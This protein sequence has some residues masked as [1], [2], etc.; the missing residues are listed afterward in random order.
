MIPTQVGSIV[1]A[2]LARK[3]LPRLGVAVSGSAMIFVLGVSMLAAAFI[4]RETSPLLLPVIIVTCYAVASVAAFVALTT[5][6]MGLA[7]SGE[8]GVTSS[9]KSAAS[10]IGA[11]LGVCVMTLV[12][13]NV[14]IS[15]MQAQ[16]D[17]AGMSSSSTT[18]AAA[19]DLL[20]GATTQDV[21]DQY[22]I[23]EAEAEQLD[24]MDRI[25]YVEAYRAQAL[26]GG[27]LSIL[28]S[29]LFLATRR[30][31]EQQKS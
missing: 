26:V 21:A 30:R 11:A 20:Y 4:V 16:M 31:Y 27:V 19:W 29:V 13:S 14:G 10:N 15:S 2:A 5:A 18:A 28:C 25:A 6:I 8:E 9:F 3:L 22:A 7:E 1:G 12:V 24:A 23:S 17:A